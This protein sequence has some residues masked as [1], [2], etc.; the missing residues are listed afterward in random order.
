MLVTVVVVLALTV[1][2]A[3]TAA[4]PAH[5]T[6]AVPCTSK[7]LVVVQVQVREAPP[8]ELVVVAAVRLELAVLDLAPVV[9]R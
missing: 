8:V 9:F 4:S 7:D 5:L 1:R 3:V 6:A 2:P